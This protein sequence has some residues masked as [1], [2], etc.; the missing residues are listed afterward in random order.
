MWRGYAS[1]RAGLWEQALDSMQQA[2]K[3]DPRVP[4]NWAEYGMTFLYLHR[5][6][7]ARTAI[8]Q[9]RAI[10][11]DNFYSKAYQ[12]FLALQESGN[13]EAAIQLTIGT[14]HSEEFDLVEAFM[15]TRVFGRR[16]EEALEAARNLPDELEIQR[17]GIM[18]REHW[19]A[20]VL[21]FMGR[22]DDARAA[23]NA[24][25]FRLQGLRSEL[26]DDYRIDLAQ[27]MMSAIQGGT[28]ED[29]QVRMQKSMAS[30]P[31]DK[32]HEMRFKL[33]YA[34]I[35]AITGLAAEAIEMLEPLFSPPSETS[36]YTVDLDPAF[37]GIRENPEFIAMMERH[38]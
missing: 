37:D 13:A 6:D 30:K 5:Y 18:L 11:P 16:F 12:A 3:L 7:E 27:A 35:Y 33:E 36:V 8:E 31:R 32:V 14:Q 29:I 38:R 9:A 4:F 25:L 22:T 15:I 2:L 20:Q 28:A 17:N 23:A 24:A 34:R 19:A 1:R 10:D 26:G 21:Y